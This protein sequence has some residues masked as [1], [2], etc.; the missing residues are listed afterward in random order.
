MIRKILFASI[1]ILILSSCTPSEAQIVA[2]IAETELAVPSETLAPTLTISPSPTFTSTILPPSTPASSPERE[3]AHVEKVID[4]DTIKI[5]IDGTTYTVRYIGVDSPESQNDEWMGQEAKDENIRLVLGQDVYLEKDVSE[6]DVYS[7][8]LR[9]VYLTDGTFVNAELV[10]LGVAESLAY[11]P[12]TKYQAIL[13]DLEL[14]A[15]ANGIGIWQSA[16][17][18]K[19]SNT[20]LDTAENIQITSVDKQAEYVDIKNLGNITVSLNGWMLRSERGDQDCYLNGNLDP[21]VTLRIWAL[22]ADD[23]EEG[24][25]CNK[26]SNI[27]NNSELDPAVLFNSSHQEVDRYP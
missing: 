9:Y 20:P 13:D 24:Y 21:G 26:G 8:L 17:T 4:G 18:P 2:A 3:K 10:K 11:P 22:A 15:I 23:E 14:E 16:P 5:I 6:T 12:D 27:W 1:V 7:R 19:P 25:H